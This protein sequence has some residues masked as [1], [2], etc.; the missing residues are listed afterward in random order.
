M[1]EETTSKED[2][3]CP[4][5]GT[6]HVCISPSQMKTD[7]ERYRWLRE[8]H[9]NPCGDFGVASLGQG[10]WTIIDEVAGIMDYTKLNVPY[11]LDR[12]IDIVKQRGANGEDNV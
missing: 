5:H 7:A 4:H 10:E 2:E 3:G 11:D 6:P 8:Q 12:A 1:T 9:N